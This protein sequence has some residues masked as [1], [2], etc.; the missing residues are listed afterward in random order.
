MSLRS[1]F[2]QA[3]IKHALILILLFFTNFAIESGIASMLRSD[4]PDPFRLGLIVVVS[5]LLIAGLLCGYL[6]FRYD[7]PV[8]I[9][10]RWPLL[11]GHLTTGGLLFV[12]GTLVLV[13]AAS[14]GN[15][16]ETQVGWGGA[17]LLLIGVL[18]LALVAHD[19]YGTLRFAAPG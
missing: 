7:A 18:Y 12:I 8:D 19:V 1:I 5:S 6:S 9:H 11:L 15:V 4:T 17:P 16:H 14:L 13:L 10:R 2:W 3:L